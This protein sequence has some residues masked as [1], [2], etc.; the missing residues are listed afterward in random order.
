MTTS[1]DDYLYVLEFDGICELHTGLDSLGESLGNILIQMLGKNKKELEKLVKENNMK[2][3][4]YRKNNYSKLIFFTN[5][6]HIFSKKEIGICKFIYNDE[7]TEDELET[8]YNCDWS[9]LYYKFVSEKE[10]VKLI[11][12]EELS[13]EEEDELNSNIINTFYEYF[14]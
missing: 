11:N 4:L 12:V 9:N 7:F 2:E 6:E 13:K 14:A 1:L 10:R 5:F 8:I 3:I